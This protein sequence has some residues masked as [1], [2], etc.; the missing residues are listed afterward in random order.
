MNSNPLLVSYPK[1]HMYFAPVYLL[2]SVVPGNCCSEL[3]F[4]GKPLMVIPVPAGGHGELPGKA[5]ERC[6]R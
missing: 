2:A 3:A 5:Q 1:R 6:S 4:L